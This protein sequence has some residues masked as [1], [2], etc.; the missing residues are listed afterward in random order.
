MTKPVVWN[1]STR[2]P[3]VWEASFPRFSLY[4]QQQETKELWTVS[5]QNTS[6]VNGLELAEVPIK[7]SNLKEAQEKAVVE[8]QSLFQ[9]SARYLAK[10]A[11]ALEET[12]PG[13]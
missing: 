8:M 4:L 10:A 9:D 6:C 3:P 11:R 5:F 13:M 7:A 1:V 12:K 2:Q